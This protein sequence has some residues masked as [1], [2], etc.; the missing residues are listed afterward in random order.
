VS[1][2]R[3]NRARAAARARLERQMA[4]RREAHRRRRLLQ[5]RI[6][7]GVAGVVLVGAVIWIVVA[8][9]SGGDNGGGGPQAAGPCVYTEDY[10]Q[11]TATPADP[12]A[13]ATVDPSATVDPTATATAA[14]TPTP[15]PLPEGV[16]DLGRPV[17]DPPRSG[18]QVITFE[19]NL[20]TIQVEMDLS[21]TPCTSNSIAFLA[22]KGYYD[23]TGG[24]VPSCHR[25]VPDIFALQCGDPSGTGFGS[26]NYHFAD[27]NLQNDRLPAYHA[28]DVA[29]ANA[30]PD[31]NSSQF[32]FVYGVG[33]LPGDYPLWGRVISGMEIIEQVAAVGY[34]PG[35][36]MQSGGGTPASDLVFTKVTAGPITPT[37]VAPPPATETATPTPT[38]TTTPTP[39]AT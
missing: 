8:T 26:P 9:V 10:P 37:S 14:A 19:T 22:S 6:A 1:S 24:D 17:A 15:S 5:A 13:T 30:G 29:M 11:P 31:T 38:A 7:G 39:G 4:A 33:P 34:L 25:I 20:G 2:E 35:S 32:F 18:F 23:N 16:V 28:G 21:K 12:S 27:E 3:D 36:E